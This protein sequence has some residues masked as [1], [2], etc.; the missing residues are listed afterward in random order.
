MAN[1][2]QIKR[3]LEHGKEYCGYCGKDVTGTADCMHSEWYD[4]Q[5]SAS[6][7][8]EGAI[9]RKIA[10]R[11]SAMRIGEEY[12]MYPE[13]LESLP[14]FDNPSKYVASYNMELMFHINSLLEAGLIKGLSGNFKL[15]G[16][17]SS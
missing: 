10:S 4:A 9:H 3:G 15:Y 14:M 7:A 6:A 17:Y 12:L 13:D 1:L 8:S 16:R 5:F 2:I 11:Q